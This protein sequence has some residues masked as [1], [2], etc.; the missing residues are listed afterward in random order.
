MVLVYP[1]S[2]QELLF[3][4]DLFT[5]TITENVQ[6]EILSCG[7]LELD[8]NADSTIY[9]SV[10]NETILTSPSDLSSEVWTMAS[11]SEQNF[12]WFWSQTTEV[13]RDWSAEPSSR[14]GDYSDTAIR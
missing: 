13:Y 10:D 12:Y 14:D 11:Q 9:R 5:S 3:I 1:R 7:L 6:T 4:W 8:R 2:N